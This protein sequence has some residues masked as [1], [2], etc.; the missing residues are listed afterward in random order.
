MTNVMEGLTTPQAGEDVNSH[1][2]F[3]K[4]LESRGVKPDAEGTPETTDTSI[5]AGLTTT[6]PV[7]GRDPETGRFVAKQAEP[8]TSQTAPDTSDDGGGAPVTSDDPAVAALLSKYGGDPEKAL[9]AFTEA[10]SLI[11]RRDEERD[12]LRDQVAKLTGI[13]ETLQAGAATPRTA[14]TVMTDEQVEQTAAAE[15]QSKGYHAAAT[16]AANASLEGGDE[17]MLR[18][19]YEQWNLEDQWEANNFLAD[20]RA[21]QR[22]QTVQPAAAADPF[23]E[24]LKAGSGIEATI[25]SLAAELGDNWK[26]VAPHMTPALDAMPPQVA[27]MIAD[28]DPEIRLAGARLVADR[29]TLI[30][31]SSAPADVSD[32]GEPEIPASVQRKLSGAAVATAGLRPAP[33]GPEGQTSREDVLRAFKDEI[34]AAETTSVASGLTY[35]K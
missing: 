25:K 14:P 17:R 23:V 28:N 10:Q 2:G 31:G 19:I 13:V 3:A 20:F 35:G 7:V 1:D 24:D 33:K 30:A 6:E 12:Q 22:L 4:L 11:G 27:A 32:T 5:A 8:D 16:A 15:I 9:K 29:A 18:S 34:M 26:V 21:F